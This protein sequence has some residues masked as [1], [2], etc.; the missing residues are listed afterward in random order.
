MFSCFVSERGEAKA[1]GHPPA[2]ERTSRDELTIVLR[3]LR[4]TLGRA[5]PADPLVPGLRRP[6]AVQVKHRPRVLFSANGWRLFSEERSVCCNIATDH[7]PSITLLERCL[8]QVRRRLEAV[9]RR[10]VAAAALEG[11]LPRRPLPDGRAARR[12]AL[13]DMQAS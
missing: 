12:S 10:R 7:M 11:A 6:L 5:P 1:A 2:A 4:G 8:V 9:P 13:P 3:P